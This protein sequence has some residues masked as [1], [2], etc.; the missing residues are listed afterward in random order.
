MLHLFTATNN[1]LQSMFGQTLCMTDWAL[2]VTLTVQCTD[3]LGVSGGNATRN[4][5][6]YS[7]GTQEKRASRMMGLWLTLHVIS[8]VTVPHTSGLLPMGPHWS[9]ELHDASWLWGGSYCPFHS[10]SSDLAFLSTHINHCCVSRL[11]AVHL[12][13][14]K[15]GHGIF[16]HSVYSISCTTAVYLGGIKV[17]FEL[18]VKE[19]L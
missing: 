3:W 19:S 13:H 15:F 14:A 4:A 2:L 17:Q 9:L 10:G 7:V 6:G 12:N 1:I 11:M 5:G 8:L 18:D 16:L